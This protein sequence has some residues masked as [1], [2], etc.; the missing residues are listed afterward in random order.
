M[1]HRSSSAA[2]SDGNI[3]S[4]LGRTSWSTVVV[5]MRVWAAQGI[6]VHGE[7]AVDVHPAFKL[8]ESFM[9]ATSLHAVFD[10]LEGLI[11]SLNFGDNGLLVDFQLSAA[12]VVVAV[13][14]HFGE[15]CGVFKAT[16]HLSQGVVGSPSG[17]E[18]FDEPLQ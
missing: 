1:Y 6:V 16:G 4:L 5:L 11:F 2:C 17:L 15:D 10:P 7:V 9:E 12:L 13:T 14:F 8:G 18:E 3:T